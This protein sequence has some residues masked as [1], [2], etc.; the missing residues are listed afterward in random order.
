MAIR[1]WRK[2][3]EDTNSLLGRFRVK[4]NFHHNF[5]YTKRRFGYY[6]KSSAIRKRKK[7]RK[8]INRSG[9]YTIDGIGFKTNKLNRNMHFGLQLQFSK[10]DVIKELCNYRKPNRKKHKYKE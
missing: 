7:Q 9:I 3:G 8:T 4:T 1:V 6:E 2:L 10:T 5:S